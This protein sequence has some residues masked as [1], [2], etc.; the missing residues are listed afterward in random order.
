MD[1]PGER[2]LTGPPGAPDGRGWRFRGRNDGRGLPARSLAGALLLAIA[3]ASLTAVAWALL[4]G[5][6]ELGLTA[7]IV[8]A[9]GGWTIGVVLRQ[10][11][12]PVLLALIMGLAAWALGL[13]FSW[14]LA[15]A[16]LPGSTR[17]LFE[18]LENTPL[19]DWLSPQLG[20]LEVA[21]LLVTVA[22]AA[23]GARPAARPA[24]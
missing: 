2:R 7:L 14:L 3:A 6:L 9:L 21:A 16:L 11:R 13:V 4:R 15:M 18:R 20:L 8:S 5:V 22:A 12:A 24:S 17:T 10:A 1:E 23:Y 19:L